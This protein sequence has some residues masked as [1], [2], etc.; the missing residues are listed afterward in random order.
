M[1]ESTEPTRLA[2]RFIISQDAAGQLR[3]CDVRRQAPPQKCH[4]FPTARLLRDQLNAQ[5][6]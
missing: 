6:A 1:T 5:Y 3:V 2:H 4:N